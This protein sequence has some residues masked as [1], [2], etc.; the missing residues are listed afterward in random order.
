MVSGRASSVRLFFIQRTVR[1]LSSGDQKRLF[2]KM[3][4]EL[5]FNDEK[6]RLRGD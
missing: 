6:W 5:D 1:M 4:F 2:K 3:I